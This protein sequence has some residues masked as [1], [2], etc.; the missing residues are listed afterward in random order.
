MP[1][2]TQ[3]RGF[4]PVGVAAGFPAT[5]SSPSPPPAPALA[6]LAALPLR[7]PAEIGR[8]LADEQAYRSRFGNLLNNDGWSW[9]QVYQPLV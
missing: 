3:Q 7:I 5:P 2:S 4:Y 1:V 9:Q 8:R 6:E